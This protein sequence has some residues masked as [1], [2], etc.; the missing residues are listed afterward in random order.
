MEK[1]NN[2][3]VKEITI[4]EAYKVHLKVLE[5]GESSSMQD[6]VD[7]YS[8]KEHVIVGAY[9]DDILIGYIIAYD[10]EQDGERFYVWMAGVDN[11]Y[12]RNG[13]LKKMM[14]YVFAWAKEHGYS[15][16]TIKTRNNRREMINFLSRNDFN[17]MS[18]E[19]KDD[20]RENRIEL[21]KDI[22]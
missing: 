3:M 12:R 2:V 8:G 19:K 17:F 10:R 5:F 11:N 6:F 7:R 1:E 21:E 9:L 18:V 15:K 20:I 13:A 16:I 22:I 4:E 14:D